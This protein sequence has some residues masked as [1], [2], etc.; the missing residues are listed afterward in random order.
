MGVYHRHPLKD[1][2]QQE[3]EAESKMLGQTLGKAQGVL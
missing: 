1:S 2:I 3:S